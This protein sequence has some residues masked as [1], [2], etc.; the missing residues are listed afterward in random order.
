MVW[1]LSDDG[2]Q[3]PT[4]TQDI[5]S[6]GSSTNTHPVSTDHRT[7]NRR[8]PGGRK[9]LQTQAAHLEPFTVNCV[10]CCIIRNRKQK[11]FSSFTQTGFFCFSIKQGS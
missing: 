10:L 5:Y 6:L 3:G 1:V 8:G 11:Y 7:G 4:S 2:K 9:M